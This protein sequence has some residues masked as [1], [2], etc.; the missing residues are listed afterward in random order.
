[1]LDFFKRGE[2]AR[3]VRLLAAQ[4]ALAP[5]AYEQLAILVHLLDDS[6]PEI[7]S[8]A[9]DTLGR[10]PIEALQGFLARSD[11][12]IGLREFFADRGVF[13]AEIPAIEVDEPLID[14]EGP[15]F[16]TEGAG[17]PASPDDPDAARASIV[18]TLANMG[19]SERLKAAIKGTREMRAVLIRS[20][21][22]MIAAA[23]LS[24]PKVSD[25]EV[26]SF[27]RMANLSEEVLRTIASNRSWMKN[28]GVVVGL[29]K[30]PKTPLALS[31]NMMSRLND[32]DLT[33]LSVDRN[34]PEP[35]R[36]AAR[37]RLLGS[38]SRG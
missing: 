35:L 24:S 1:L 4:G 21:N 29:T 13:P 28:Y 23:V 25:S 18:S 5:R 38:V 30:N 26:E 36:I 11:V 3:D 6:D 7:R 12:P 16:D 32:R 19:F 14:T 22:K 9:D 10:I 17:D 8:V 27:A 31:M 33:M 2:V 37:K 34:I 15:L 20:P